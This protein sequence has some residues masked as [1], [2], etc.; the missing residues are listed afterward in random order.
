MYCFRLEI[1]DSFLAC[2]MGE[3]DEPLMASNACQEL[4]LLLLLFGR[5]SELKVGDV[6][7]DEAVDVEVFGFWHVLAPCLPPCK[8]DCVRTDSAG[9][10][11]CGWSSLT[12]SL[13]A[14]TSC[15]GDGLSEERCSCW[16]PRRLL[17]DSGMAATRSVKLFSNELR[18]RTKR[19]QM[20]KKTKRTSL[21][22]PRPETSIL[23]RVCRYYGTSD[24]DDEER[25]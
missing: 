6:V 11:Y 24:D 13:S 21:R 22:G 2:A 12:G 7:A 15:A 19:Q 4:L 3:S 1:G 10:E 25:A 8:V 18:S 14:A 9:K 5:V 16:L 17:H 23:C 20:T